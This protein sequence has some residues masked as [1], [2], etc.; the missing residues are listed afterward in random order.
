M[1]KTSS[2]IEPALRRPPATARPPVTVVLLSG[3]VL[4]AVVALLLGATTLPGRSTPAG[5]TTP[6]GEAATLCTT[7]AEPAKPRALVLG[8]AAVPGKAGPKA[9][10]RETVP[11][12]RP[13]EEA[14][15]RAVATG[16]ARVCTTL[17]A[18]SRSPWAPMA[19]LGASVLKLWGMA[20]MLVTLGSA[21]AVATTEVAS[22]TAVAIAGGVGSAAAAL[23]ARRTGGLVPMTVLAA[24]G[25]TLTGDEA[26][27]AGIDT[28]VTGVMA[29]LLCAMNC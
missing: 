2:V 8:A 26:A 25:A 12:G 20:T 6:P 22:M 21:W 24:A 29:L 15:P 7:P 27:P 28:D 16:S 17:G 5:R 23:C 14:V 3:S 4:P 18:V 13:T 11:A 1:L 9:S 10:G 19:A